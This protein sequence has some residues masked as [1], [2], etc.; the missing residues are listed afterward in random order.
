[1]CSFLFVMFCW[2][3]LLLSSSS[4]L[5]S[6][7]LF[8]IKPFASLQ[9]AFDQLLLVGSGERDWVVMLIE[10]SFMW[11]LIT[12]RCHLWV[13]P[14]PFV[15]PFCPSVV[16]K[17]QCLCQCIY[18]VGSTKE[19]NL[20]CDCWM[21]LEIKKKLILIDVCCHNCL[22]LFLSCNSKIDHFLSLKGR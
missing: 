21:P 4:T 8:I 1:M 2:V 22:F 12:W 18:A 14:L 7:W 15:C 20:N 13:P 19:P 10:M 9:R 5:I 3:L 16:V 6:S 11:Q 17:P